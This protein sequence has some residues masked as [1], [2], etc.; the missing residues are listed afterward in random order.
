L[1]KSDSRDSSAM[2]KSLDAS[3]AETNTRNELKQIEKDMSGFEKSTLRWS[4]V[5][6]VMSS[7]AALFVC[8][9]WW[10]MHT[11]SRD[12]HDLAIAAKNQADRTKDVADAAKSQ[13]EQ[14]I[15]QTG[16]MRES[17]E[18]TD[19][20]IRATNDLATQAK[21]SADLSA[22]GLK[23]SQD[24]IHLDER[25]WIG[26]IDVQTTGGAETHDTFRVESVIIVIHNSGKTPALKISGQCCLF[27][28]YLWSEPIPDYDSEFRKSEE[29]RA[30]LRK[31]DHEQMM[32]VTKQHPELAA[33]IAERE[34]EFEALDSA[35]EKTM[36]HAG[37]V[38]APGVTHA[39]GIIS[40]AQ[41]GTRDERDMP[42]TIYVLGKFTYRDMFPGTPE[43]T[44]KFCLMRRGGQLSPCAPKATG[45]IKHDKTRLSAGSVLMLEKLLFAAERWPAFDAFVVVSFPV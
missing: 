26:L 1:N 29:M 19:S 33:T 45:W 28:S 6:V 4:R 24:A 15:A 2:S 25:P 43:H 14:A 36:F 17:L 18:K 22:A 40:K 11:S 38:L 9:Q 42:K 44:T 16:K 35:M 21:R 37:E 32:A 27:S 31:R 34:K 30:A 7:L 13:S 41:W 5:A 39:S 23:A 12:T 10:E 3:P 8:A 20:L